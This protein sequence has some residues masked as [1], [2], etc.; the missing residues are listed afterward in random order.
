MLYWENLCS[1]KFAAESDSI[2]HA[3]VVI[4]TGNLKFVPIKLMRM[5][6]PVP[7]YHFWH[8]CSGAVLSKERFIIV[9][10]WY[11]DKGV[12]CTEVNILLQLTSVT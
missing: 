1:E 9:I 10:Q 4:M 6:Q 11:I 2:P 3:S 7:R 12:N 8:P 5:I